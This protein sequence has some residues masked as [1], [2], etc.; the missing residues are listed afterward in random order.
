MESFTRIELVHVFYRGLLLLL[1]SY[2]DFK[3][4]KALSGGASSSNRYPLCNHTED[5]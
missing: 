1:R 4:E 5:V 2:G 3:A